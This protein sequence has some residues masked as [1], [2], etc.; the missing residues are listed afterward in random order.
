M[1][2]TPNDPNKESENLDETLPTQEEET[3]DESLSAL[4]ELF[5]GDTPDIEEVWVED[6]EVDC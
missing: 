5:E 1:L 2:N 3:R 6:E 4:Q